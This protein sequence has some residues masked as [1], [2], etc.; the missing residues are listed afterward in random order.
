MQVHGNPESFSQ[1][2]SFLS[3]SN[4]GP[5]MGYCRCNGSGCE[6]VTGHMEASLWIVGRSRLTCAGVTPRDPSSSRRRVALRI[7]APGDM[8]LPD[9][10]GGVNAIGQ[11]A[12][13]ARRRG[14]ARGVACSGAGWRLSGVR[15]LS[16]LQLACQEIFDRPRRR[17][18][19]DSDSPAAP[20]LR[21]CPK[22]GRIWHP[23]G[24]C[25]MARIRKDRPAS[26]AAAPGAH[27]PAPASGVRPSVPASPASASLAP[28]GPGGQPRLLSASSTS[29]RNRL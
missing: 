9:V 22:P 12:Q 2:A 16:A 21:A 14:C 13:Q 28:H 5:F 18:D 25:M 15:C 7:L 1:C 27:F 3:R 4:C 19:T 17:S 20:L 23:A 10:A 8:Q 11:S 26:P 24:R 6:S 29:R